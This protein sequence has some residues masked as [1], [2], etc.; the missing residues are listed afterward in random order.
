MSE[1]AKIGHNVF[2]TKEQI[3]QY[4]AQYVHCDEQ[5]QLLSDERLKIRE[6][7]SELGLDTKA[8]QDAVSRAKKD[9]KKKDGYDESLRIIVEALGE[10]NHDDLFAYIDRREL[11]KEKARE[12]REKAKEKADEF[13]AAP[14]RKPKNAKAIGIQ[15]AE[16]I[17]NVIDAG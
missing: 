14:D 8:F 5:S 17:A 10:L 11:E 12:A 2:S 13:K 16:A 6:K 4:V 15:Q 9:R 7:V 3:K 1:T